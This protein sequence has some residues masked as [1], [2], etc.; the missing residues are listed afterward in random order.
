MEE[1]RGHLIDYSLG[2]FAGY[3][4]F[5][6]TGDLDMSCALTVTLSANGTLLTGHFTSLHLSSIGQPSLDPSGAA[7]TFV[8]Q[9][10]AADFGP[11]A[12]TIS[13]SGSLSLPTPAS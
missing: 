11:T 2:N 6:T 12:V 13:S 4:F 7:A 3:K 9:L 8:N 1:Y 5:S 10:S